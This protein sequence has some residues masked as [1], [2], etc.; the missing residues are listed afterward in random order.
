M[1]IIQYIQSTCTTST[2]DIPFTNHKLSATAEPTRW[3]TPTA[4]Y[5]KTS[6]K[7][8]TVSN[9]TAVMKWPGTDLPVPA[10]DRDE[11]DR[12]RKRFMKLDKVNLE[13][14]ALRFMCVP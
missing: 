2:N 5:S 11:I 10:V 7:R 3:G 8:A 13:S 4:R 1:I 9:G 14:P 6:C 12:L